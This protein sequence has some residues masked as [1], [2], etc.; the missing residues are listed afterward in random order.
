[1]F[2]DSGKGRGCC[3]YFC[4]LANLRCDL[5]FFSF[6]FFWREKVILNIGC[7]VFILDAIFYMFS[8]E[9]K[10]KVNECRIWLKMNTFWLCK[11]RMS[12]ACSF[13]E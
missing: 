11:L 5:D 7:E 10:K 12:A 13:R 6:F 9:K 1:M 2:K 4:V 8:T 3:V